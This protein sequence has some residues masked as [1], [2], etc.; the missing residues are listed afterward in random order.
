MNLALFRRRIVRHGALLL[1]PVA[2]LLVIAEPVVA[3]FGI[4]P[5]YVDNQ[6]LTR[7]T[8]YE[9]KILLVRSDPTDDLRAQI[10][11]NIPEIESWF[12]VD[13]GTDFIM[14]KGERQ[15]PIVIRVTVPDDAQFRKYGGAIRIRTSPTEQRS[16]GGVSIALG[17]Q[18]DVNLEVVDKI[19]DFVVRRIRVSDLETGR[20]KWG[21]FFPG[22]IRF[23]MTIENTGNVEYGPTRVV[24]DIYDNDLE[25]LLETT[26]NTNEIDRVPPFGTAE[27]V[28]E[29]P[30]RLPPGLYRAK[31]SIYNGDMVAQTNEVSVGVS[32]VGSVL[33]YVGYSFDGLSLSD[34]L[35]VAAALFIPILLFAVF[36]FFIIRTRRRMMRRARRVPPP[37]RYQ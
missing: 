28:A 12:T 8:V 35:K 27:V 3:G 14:P 15:V 6:R 1:I 18:V 19:L 29:L 24:F 37:Q 26:E 9:Q 25:T 20:T 30:T 10:T 33:G 21:L 5:P 31:Y 2:L 32:N 36:A 16:G 13:R 22:K 11:Y 7:G 17:A 4:T 23:L 34:K